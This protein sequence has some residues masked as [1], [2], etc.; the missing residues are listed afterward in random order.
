MLATCRSYLCYL[1]AVL[2]AWLSSTAGGVTQ[3]IDQEPAYQMSADWSFKLSARMLGTYMNYPTSR[4]RPIL[5]ISAD[6][7]QRN[8]I[9]RKWGPS[10][11]YEELWYHDES[12]T[13]CKRNQVIPPL[14]GKYGV[15]EIADTEDSAAH[16]RALT[17]AVVRLLLDI[18]LKDGCL[19]DLVVPL[20]LYDQCGSDL[21]SK[22]FYRAYTGSAMDQMV[23]L[24]MISEP[25]KFDRYYRL[26]T[27]EGEAI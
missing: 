9:S 12:A 4:I 8:P 19:T 25:R 14:E 17:D 7:R 26:R 24:H 3:P 13:G 27:K 18:N 2:I 1:C 16:T 10:S 15:I 11:R 20:R 22:Y 6:F 5:S 23:L 21:G